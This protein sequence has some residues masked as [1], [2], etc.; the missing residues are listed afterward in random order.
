[1]SGNYDQDI[2]AEVE[3]TFDVCNTTFIVTR[4]LYEITLKSVFVTENGEGFFLLV[5]RLDK[6]SM[7]V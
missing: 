4:G 7:N 5:N 3:L 6:I 2:K 1:M